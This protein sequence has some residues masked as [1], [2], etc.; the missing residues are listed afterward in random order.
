[1]VRPTVNTVKTP[2]DVIIFCFNLDCQFID[3]EFD[4]TSKLNLIGMKNFSLFCAAL[5]QMVL[6]QA[7]AQQKLAVKDTTAP[8]PVASASLP[9]TN[10]IPKVI[11]I[12]T[13]HAN[14]SQDTNAKTT[15]KPI[16]AYPNNIV[17]FTISEP[18]SFL[19][20]R[21]SDNAKVVMYVNGVEMKGICTGWYRNIS[22]VQLNSGQVPPMGTTADIDIILK[23]NDTTKSAW[24]FFY[25]NT[26]TEWDNFVDV[27]ASIG[28][29]GMSAL[30]KDAG[31]NN[32]TIVYY[33]FWTFWIWTGL[34]VVIILAFLLLAVKTSA[35]RD[36][37][38]G[39]YSLS[40]TQLLFWTALAIGAFIY[41]LV[42]TDM[43]SSFNPSILYMLGISLGTTGVASTIDSRFNQSN[44]DLP[45]KTH[46]IFIKDVLTDG[47]EYSVQ[48]IQV[49]AWNLVLGIYFIFYTI[50]NKSMPEFSSTL[51]FLAGFSSASYL[52]AKVPEN[53]T[54][55]TA[56]TTAGIA[57]NAVG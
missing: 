15:A 2:L 6:L 14:A 38:T 4:S 42:L 9:Q 30:Q 40:L 45:K 55:K 41:T 50:D 27:D 32:L 31:V 54:A 43:L 26:K 16:V 19:N 37:P 39:A 56:G 47:T 13:V 25:S 20:S 48:R 57:P 21:P 10:L 29:E 44:P 18:L 35:I 52:G 23:R 7:S 12:R 53:N 49:F 33:Y 22:R 24:N 3:N 17:R 36:T 11:S 1:V 8:H 46:T 51:L 5:L 28:W 34:F